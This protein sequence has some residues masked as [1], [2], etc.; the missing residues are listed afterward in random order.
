MLPDAYA[1]IEDT[2]VVPFFGRPMNV[3]LGS[4]VMARK[5]ESRLIPAIAFPAGVL[6]FSIEFGDSIPSLQGVDS[7]SSKAASFELQD[8][9][10][11][12]LMFQQF[13]RWMM[14]RTMYWQYLRQHFYKRCCFNRLR[15]EVV[16]LMWDQFLKDPRL[17]APLAVDFHLN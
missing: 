9:A 7:V 8:Y 14:G 4:A 10:S 15:P 12:A 13:E 17:A 6:R 1:D 11:T 16:D 3:M 5:S 2:H